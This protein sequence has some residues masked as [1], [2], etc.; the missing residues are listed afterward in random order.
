MTLD[1]LPI[2]ATAVITRVGGEGALR[3]RL[4]DMGLIPG[5]LLSVNKIVRPFDTGADS[6]GFLHSAAHGY[7]GGTG[8]VHQI[9]GRAFRA[10]QD[11]HINTGAFGRVKTPPHPSVT[12]SLQ[13]G[14]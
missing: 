4:L 5:T 14:R 6:G 11:T 12:G 9:K 1:K 8:Q 7:P 13:S 10:K 3:L 2:G